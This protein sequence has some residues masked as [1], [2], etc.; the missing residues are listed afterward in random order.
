LKRGNITVHK[1]S[2]KFLPPPKNPAKI[3]VMLFPGAY[4]Y[5]HM[6]IGLLA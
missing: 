4:L 6:F 3:E 2:T 1:N 5:I